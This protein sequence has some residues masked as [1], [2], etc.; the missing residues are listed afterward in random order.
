MARPDKLAEYLLELLAP[1]G[2]VSARRMFGGAG[3][4]HGG[5]MF[6]LLARE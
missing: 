6:G 4:F 3:L 5:T 2:P 1:L